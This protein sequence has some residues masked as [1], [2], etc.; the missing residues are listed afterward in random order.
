MA[1]AGY[2]GSY[3]KGKPVTGLADAA[4]LPNAKIFHAGTQKV[5]SVECRATSVLDPRPS[6]LDSA[7]VTAGGRVLG[8]TAWAETL[9]AARE[10][11][12][13]AVDKI[14]FD[15]AHYRRDIA[16]K[17]LPGARPANAGSPAAQ[18]K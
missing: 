13:H 10:A 8:V 7:V 9:P 4:K 3:A 6:A 16:A 18:T 17:A 5:S 1:S 12:Y 11:A 15:G 2:P 14:A